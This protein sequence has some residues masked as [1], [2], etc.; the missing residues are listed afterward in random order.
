MRS[1]C[2]EYS[3]Q[4]HRGVGQFNVAV[5]GLLTDKEN[6]LVIRPAIKGIAAVES[7]RQ[8]SRR[9]FDEVNT[10]Q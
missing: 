6:V 3:I 7:S 8:D 9:D 2:I 1:I 10:I 5:P 4:I